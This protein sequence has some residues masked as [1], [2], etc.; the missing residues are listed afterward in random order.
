MVYSNTYMI[1]SY[2]LCSSGGAGIPCRN[3]PIPK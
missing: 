3:A 1:E 2:S